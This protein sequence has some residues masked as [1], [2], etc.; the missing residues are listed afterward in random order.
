M[1]KLKE[2]IYRDNKEKNKSN[3]LNEYSYNFEK[4]DKNEIKDYSKV[5]HFIN[6]EYKI[7]RVK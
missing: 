6:K 3:I 7:N 2:F 5:Y 1:K 4:Y